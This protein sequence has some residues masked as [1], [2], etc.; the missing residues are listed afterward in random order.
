M[1][2]ISGYFNDD[3]TPFNPDLIPKPQLCLGCINDE[4]ENQEILCNL[5]RLDQKNE[6]EFK[7]YAYLNKYQ[8]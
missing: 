4:D 7:C 3:G 8:K 6:K 5:T 1:E 2:H